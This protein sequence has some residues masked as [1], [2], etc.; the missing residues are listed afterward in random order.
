MRRISFKKVIF[1]IIPAVLIFFAFFND[2]L[3]FTQETHF[4]N[5]V[6]VLEYHHIDPQASDYTITPETFK[7]HL[8]ALKEHH[9]QVISMQEFIDFLNGK[10]A[11]PSN[12]VVL[13]FDDGYE[14]FYQYAYP[15]LKEQGLVATNFIIV[16]YLGTN[17]G[18]PFLN[19]D[20]IKKMKNDGF[21][22][23]SHTFNSHDFAADQNGKP[24]DP[25]T[26]PIFLKSLNRMETEQEY[27]QR[28][29]ADLTQAEQLI[30]DELGTQDKM[31]CFP[32][33][34]YNDT[35][36]KIGEQVGI[37]HYFTGKDG[38]N[39]TGDKLI[40]RINAGSLNV[41]PNKLLHKLND[42]TTYIGKL[43]IILKNYIESRRMSA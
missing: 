23:Y 37:Q 4:T 20:E 25:L 41:T 11:V 26:N 24:T 13:T 1:I 22:F 18:T 32:H 40:K 38:L 36:L 15:I 42:E 43:K 29:K 5:R 33:G 16:N 30:Q 8:E 3:S 21:S 10:H 35:L 19:W 39:S 31:F 9:Y 7:R 12:A 28:V 17:P 6:A 34:R 27:E 2:R 14:S